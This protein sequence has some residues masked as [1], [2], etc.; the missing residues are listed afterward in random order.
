MSILAAASWSPLMALRRAVV[1]AP[2]L[3]SV[4][5]RRRKRVTLAWPLE[6]LACRAVK[7]IICVFSLSRSALVLGSSTST[8]L[9]IPLWAATTSGDET[10]SSE[11]LILAFAL[12]S[13]STTSV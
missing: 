13:S 1:N 6:A 4:V 11:T 7:I 12:S 10:C 9:F 2:G 5:S 3:L 8:V